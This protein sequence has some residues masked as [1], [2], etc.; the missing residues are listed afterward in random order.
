MWYFNTAQWPCPPV[1]W[2]GNFVVYLDPSW[3]DDLEARVVPCTKSFLKN[4]GCSVRVRTFVVFCVAILILATSNVAWSQTVQGVITGTVTDQTGAVVPNV[5]VT[6][7]NVGTNTSE[8]T[9]T[10]S[11]GSYRFSLVPPGQYTADVKAP[12]F[13]EV[14]ASGIVRG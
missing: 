11:D 6:I 5:P 9:V 10:D 7:T 13:A 4:W 14:R 8:S 12:N 1:L 2:V 3:R